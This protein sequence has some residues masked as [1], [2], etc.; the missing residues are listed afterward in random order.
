M[1]RV[2]YLLLAM[3]A[4]AAA[5]ASAPKPQP[6]PLVGQIDGWVMSDSNRWALSQLDAIGNP[7][8]P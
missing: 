5:L 8:L 7:I 6:V 1:R 2:D 4:F 3:I